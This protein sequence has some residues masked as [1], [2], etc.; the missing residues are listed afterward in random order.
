MSAEKASALRAAINAANLA[1]IIEQRKA[2]LAKVGS[3]TAEGVKIRMPDSIG[4]PTKTPTSP[5]VKIVQR[6]GKIRSL[7]KANIGKREE[8]LA[9]AERK[10]S[11]TKLQSAAAEYIA[12]FNTTSELIGLIEQGVLPEAEAALPAYKRKLDLL[13][14]LPKRYPT[15][16]EGIAELEV[17]GTQATRPGLPAGRERD[18]VRGSQDTAIHTQHD[19]TAA[20]I[21]LLTKAQ[22]R[23]AL[24]NAASICE[25]LGMTHSAL[26]T[27]LKRLEFEGYPIDSRR[28]P[29]GGYK[30]GARGRD[31]VGGVMPVERHP[32]VEEYVEK[33]YRD[34]LRGY[35]DGA[36]VD[37]LI[38]ILSPTGT[39]DAIQVGDDLLAAVDTIFENNQFLP[40][41]VGGRI[42]RVD[43]VSLEQAII[44][45]FG[46]P[47][48]E[49]PINLPSEVRLSDRES[50]ILH[51]L[52]NKSSIM[53]VLDLKDIERELERQDI[54]LGNPA[55]TI[56]TTL[57]SLRKKIRA[58]GLEI[59]LADQLSG[60]EKRGYFLKRATSYIQAV[61]REQPVK[62]PQVIDTGEAEFGL[63]S[64]VDVSTI[65]TTLKTYRHFLNAILQLDLSEAQRKQGDGAINED[66]MQE[67]TDLGVAKIDAKDI[68][69]FRLQALDKIEQIVT[70]A[71]FEEQWLQISQQNE[72]VGIL[73]LHLSVLRDIRG[74]IDG[75]AEKINGIE[76]LRR[77]FK[78]PQLGV[79]GYTV[80]SSEGAK[81]GLVYE[82]KVENDGVSSI[83]VHVE[84]PGNAA[85]KGNTL[86][87]LNKETAEDSGITRGGTEPITF[88]TSSV[89]P[90]SMA[91]A[92]AVPVGKREL[93]EIERNRPTLR[94]EVHGLFNTL[95]D[96]KEALF[97]GIAGY[98]EVAATF[99]QLTKE[100]LDTLVAGD[101]ISKTGRRDR[102][103][104]DVVA[105]ATALYLTD[106]NNKFLDAGLKRQVQ[107]VVN[108]EY[109]AFR[110]LVEDT[111]NNGNGGKQGNK[112]SG[113]EG[114][115]PQIRNTIRETLQDI[116]SHDQL[117]RPIYPA[118]VG[119]VYTRLSDAVFNSLV[120]D[121]LVVFTRDYRSGRRF[122]VDAIEIA[123]A[124]YLTDP[125][126]KDTLD[127]RMKKQVRGI[128]TQ[129]YEKL[130]EEKN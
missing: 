11:P 18:T 72:S 98:D 70:S 10:V 89:K 2:T 60:D 120:E 6:I 16:Q 26:R 20:L 53:H 73:L 82:R 129:E 74:T 102:S 112:A 100:V 119:M 110:D 13:E 104:F 52:R 61:R 118:A 32:L 86:L 14:A 77:R 106:A 65:A 63:L 36:S 97:S 114:R 66:I 1:D 7:L 22:T 27:A 4:D 58:S 81:V 47:V 46:V 12:E 48:T 75:S 8:D 68:L 95:F 17:S 121:E 67:L 79:R 88:G 15:L 50:V 34:A 76:L 56:A 107:Q 99:P 93:L 62:E 57:V 42:L 23:G 41:T 113:I 94:E 92:A 35:L 31:R 115:D 108:E 105:I 55:T 111:G 38:Q 64:R 54:K 96:A 51:L 28:G 37:D 71:D 80:I 83:V 9:K 24:M 84:I 127:G 40:I 44:R 85:Y 78:D 125:K 25:E 59:I 122:T 43:R 21:D 91:S 124:L 33:A 130:L 117:R 101:Y 123:I 69:G 126:R 103:Q 109:E 87:E 116:L 90:D 29:Q 49:E 30:M 19:R 45:N 3:R 128:V 39:R 5:E